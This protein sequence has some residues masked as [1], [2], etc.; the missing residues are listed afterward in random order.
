M[1]KNKMAAARNGNKSGL[2][3]KWRIDEKPVKI[4]KWDGTAVKN[5][6]DD[7][8][9][10]FFLEELGYVESTYLMDGRLL[11]CTIAVAFAAFALVWDYVNPFP[12]SRPVL[13]IC[14]CSYFFVTAIL[15]LYQFLAE[16]GIFLVALNKDKAGIDPDDV[17]QIS[18]TLLR[19]DDNYELKMQLI[20]GQ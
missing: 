19:Y 7:A 9:K 1:G 13:I 3:E 17:W 5:S 11:I 20:N 18:S 15:T 2:L 12:L 10:N 16:K 6:L 4:D 14:V 8:A